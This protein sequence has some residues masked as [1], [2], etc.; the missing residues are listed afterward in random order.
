MS[1]VTPSRRRTGPS[2]GDLR[3]AAIL[4]VAGQMFADRSYDAVT[5][6]DL[7]SGAGISRTSFYFYF[8]TKPAV[9]TALMAQVWDE[10]AASH[11]WFD[12]SGPAPELLRTQLGIS[13]RLW[14]ANSGLLSC[15]AT[16]LP[17][18]DQLRDFVT[19]AKT[20]Y[21][22]RA[23]AK[24]RRDQAAGTATTAIP[25]ERLAEMIAAIRD[26]EYAKLAHKTDAE[27]DATVNDLVT[28]I[29]RLVY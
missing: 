1:Q 12:S 27:L 7:A 4:R 15:A 10:L 16:A 5:I 18:S 29:Q 14:R 13:A 6:D 21:D 3:E 24:I 25:A 20:R 2:K 17:S 8:P 23:A 11:V 9:L 26:A 19:Q 28:A 22:E